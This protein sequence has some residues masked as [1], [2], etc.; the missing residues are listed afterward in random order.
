MG[1]EEVQGEFEGIA[2][3]FRGF[4]TGVRGATQAFSGFPRVQGEIHSHLK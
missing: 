4:L 2:G 3:S 1:S